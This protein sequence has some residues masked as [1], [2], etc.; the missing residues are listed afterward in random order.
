[1]GCA[2]GIGASA[3][4]GA[5]PPPATSVPEPAEP[6]ASASPEDAEPRAT[7]GEALTKPTAGDEPAALESDTDE[8]E[9]PPLEVRYHVS[10]EGLRV[11]VSGVEFIPRA[12][13]V[14][15]GSGWGVKIDV[16][17]RARDDLPHVLYEPDQGPL[18]FFAIVERNGTKEERGDQRQGQG[19]EYVTTDGIEFSRTW[20]GDMGMKP[21][22]AGERLE[23]QVGLW[24][25]GKSMTRHRPLKGFL[26]V[27]MVGGS[28]PQAV[29][30]PPST[31]Q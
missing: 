4:G 20:P 30:S 25:V 18:A 6:S 7:P 17:A 28:K 15:V 27:K 11:T 26:T 24:G 9:P 13:P 16:Q 8:P 12:T 19:E 23:L 29:V 10:Q 3:C 2:L 22:A 14:R 5:P 1:M 31:A 21:L